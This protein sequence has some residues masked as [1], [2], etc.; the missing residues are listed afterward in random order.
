M[1]RYRTRIVDTKSHGSSSTNLVR[2][3]WR[4]AVTEP[5]TCP[6]NTQVDE[7][8]NN[9]VRI[10]GFGELDPFVDNGLSAAIRINDGELLVFK[11]LGYTDIAV[12]NMLSMIRF[13]ELPTSHIEY[14][15]DLLLDEIDPS[16]IKP[17]AFI[18]NVGPLY[19]R[20]ELQGYLSSVPD[21]T[22]SAIT[23]NNVSE[24]NVNE[25]GYFDR[26]FR[27]DTSYVAISMTVLTNHVIWPEPTTTKITFVRHSVEGYTDLFDMIHDTIG[28]TYNLVS[29]NTIE[30]LIVNAD[31]YL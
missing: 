5:I 4:E 1:I 22:I 9:N 2:T 11:S 12:Y 14:R 18:T 31:M 13:G 29:N 16:V 19:G 28:D 23:S 24:S 10:M 20:N 8:M 25:I 26:V 7:R 17:M 30:T 21:L 6:V 27:P 15:S 3:N